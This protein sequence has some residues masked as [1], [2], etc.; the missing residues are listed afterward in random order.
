MVRTLLALLLLATATTFVAAQT[1]SDC[2]LTGFDPSKDYFPKKLVP[3]TGAGFTITYKRSGKLLKAPTGESYYLQLCHAPDTTAPTDGTP[4]IKI[5]VSTVAV[6][7]SLAALDGLSTLG[8]MD[9]VKFLAPLDDPTIPCGLAAKGNGSMTELTSS[10]G[11]DKYGVLFTPNPVPGNPKAVSYGGPTADM[12]P[13]QRAQWLYFL[14]SFFNM[15]D[16]AADLYYKVQR[17]YTCRK[18]QVAKTA[19]PKPLVAVIAQADPGLNANTWTVSSGTYWPTLIADAGGVPLSPVGGGVNVAT[20]Q[21]LKV[22]NGTHVIVDVT[23]RTAAATEFRFADWLKAVGATG[24]IMDANAVAVPAIGNKYVYGVDARRSALGHD[25]FA[26]TA[27]LRPNYVL[28]DM[29]SVLYPPAQGTGYT[30]RYMRS[31]AADDGF[32][33]VLDAAQCPNPLPAGP[34][35][36]PLAVLPGNADDCLLNAAVTQYLGASSVV[37]GADAG[38][39]QNG[40]GG[41]P[42]ASSSHPLAGTILASIVCVGLVAGFLVFVAPKLARK[43]RERKNMQYAQQ[44]L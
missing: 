37:P 30:R 42:I 23:N 44:M 20:D 40:T 1:T 18:Q 16:T 38:N 36:A 2:P 7:N 43:W 6:A 26:A 17:T 4:V 34:L 3:D 35:T 14:A 24:G 8:V 28:Q 13:L 27:A 21:L 31:I 41:V 12:T 9:K 32:G 33:A 22:L 25:D 19:S 15:E 10:V 5:P 29:M 11:N 39:S